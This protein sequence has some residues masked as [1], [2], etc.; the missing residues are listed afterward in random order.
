MTGETG[1]WL[2]AVTAAADAA[3]GFD[4]L[5]RVAGEPVRVLT[6]EPLAALV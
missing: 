3:Q 2:Y 5:T 1:V 6:A 4:G